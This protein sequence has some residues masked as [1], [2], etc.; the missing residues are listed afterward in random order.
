[1]LAA[2]LCQWAGLANWPV[3][4]LVDNSMEATC[5]LQ[6][7]LWTL[8]TRFEPAADIHGAATTVQRFHVGLTPPIVFDCRLKPWYTDVLE[9]DEATKIRVDQRIHTLL[10][11]NLR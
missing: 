10:P 1:M 9:V 11:P 2:E 6:E 3:I 4:I 8:F 7:F 5:S